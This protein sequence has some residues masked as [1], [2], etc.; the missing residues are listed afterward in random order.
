[1][2]ST[3]PQILVFPAHSKCSSF[4]VRSGSIQDAGE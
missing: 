4:T 2:Q 1:L 3:A